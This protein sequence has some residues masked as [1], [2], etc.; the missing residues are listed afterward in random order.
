MCREKYLIIA[1][2]FFRAPGADPDTADELLQQEANAFISTVL[3]CQPLSSD[4]KKSDGGKC[5][6]R[7][8][9]MSDGT[10]S[11]N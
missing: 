8:W 6:R 9:S 5:G 11:R 7:G 10:Y 4:W 1:D 2:T 3:T